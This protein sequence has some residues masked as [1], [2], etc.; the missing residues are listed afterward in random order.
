MGSHFK[1]TDYYL[2]FQTSGVNFFFTD[3]CT[4]YYDKFNGITI[5]TNNQWRYYIQSDERARAKELYKEFYKDVGTV[6]TS[7]KTFL[8]AKEE[9]LRLQ[10]ELRDADR[11]ARVGRAAAAGLRR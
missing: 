4:R 10:Q 7:A 9:A 3:I 2:L 8:A 1:S 6:E 11:R 5:S